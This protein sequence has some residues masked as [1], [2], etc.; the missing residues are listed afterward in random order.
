MRGTRTRGAAPHALAS[1]AAGQ[2]LLRPGAARVRRPLVPAGRRA[3]RGV[4]GGR[5]LARTPGLSRDPGR[6]ARDRGDRTRDRRT[7]RR[8]IRGRL[9]RSRRG[10]DPRASARDNARQP[11][12]HLR[13]GRPR[14]DDRGEGARPC[15]RSGGGDP[16]AAGRRTFREP[17]EHGARTRH[18]DLRAERRNR[19]SPR[20]CR[21]IARRHRVRAPGR[22]R[23][24]RPASA[25][26]LPVDATGRNRGTRARPPPHAARIRTQARRLYRRLP[27]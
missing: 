25:G 7:P 3:D 9:R 16:A 10:R 19:L 23:R 21:T 13:R 8:R 24:G 11:A 15:G 17:G 27:R 22:R 6:G 12:R 1:V 4:R 5:L 26:S 14:A 18:R 20:P 2:R